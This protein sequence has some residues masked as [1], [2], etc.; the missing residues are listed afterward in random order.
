MGRVELVDLID[1]TD[2]CDYGDGDKSG[3]F[4]SQSRA[5]RAQD[6]SGEKAPGREVDEVRNFIEMGN[7]RTA[8]HM[9]LRGEIP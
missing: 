6:A 1:G 9:G 4:G 7:L 3:V 5:F 2:H 8:S